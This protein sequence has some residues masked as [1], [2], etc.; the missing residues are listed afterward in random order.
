[1]TNDTTSEL[2]IGARLRA[3]RRNR[4][5]TLEQLGSAT[6]L[7]KGFIS[8]V[9]RDA[10]SPSVASLLKICETLGISI[11]SLFEAGDTQLVRANEARRIFLGGRNVVDWVLTPRSEKRV[12]LLHTRLEPG[13]SGGD[14]SYR[15]PIDV[16]VAYV[17][18]GRLDL[19]IN[20]EL[21]PLE[22]GD[23]IT[24]AGNDPHSWGNPS[25]KEPAEVLWLLSPALE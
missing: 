21:Y 5:M 22:K 9:E 25:T 12:Q 8:H 13:G 14:E 20:G 4:G 16:E 19:R 15:L 7:S 1:M 6:Q 24:F 11:G 18:D 17:L 3:A 10:T 23:A 2:G